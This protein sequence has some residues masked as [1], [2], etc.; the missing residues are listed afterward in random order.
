M[1]QNRPGTSDVPV[2]AA[3]EL[4]LLEVFP[5]RSLCMPLQFTSDWFSQHIPVWTDV[6]RDLRGKPHL[7]FLEIGSYEGRSA[8]WLL[9]NILT[10][11]GSRL[12]CIDIFNQDEEGIACWKSLGLPVPADG[13]LEKTFDENIRAAGGEKKVTKLKGA[14]REREC[15]SPYRGRSLSCAFSRTFPRANRGKGMRRMAEPCRGPQARSRNHLPV[16]GDLRPGKSW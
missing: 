4:A 14:S 3:L 11:P 6:L 10:H 12:T 8:C 9:E 13:T 1:A 7:H 15:R 16:E 2:S 5:I